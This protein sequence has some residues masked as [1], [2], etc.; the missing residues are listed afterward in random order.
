MSARPFVLVTTGR[1][2]AAPHT[3]VPGRVRPPRPEVHLAE[4]LIDAI[5]AAGG[6]PLLLP[7]TPLDVATLAGLLERVDAVVISGGAF[8]IHP[9]H[10]GQP[11]RGRVDSPDEARTGTELALIRAALDVD[12]PLLGVCGGMQ[13]MAVATG[14]SLI[15]DIAT[16]LA[17]SLPHEQPG[18]P[19][20]PSHRVDLSPGRL[21]ELFGASVEVNSTHHQAVAHPGAF[22]VTGRAPDGVVEAI[23][24]PGHRFAVG[25]QWH[26]ELLGQGALFAGLVGR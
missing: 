7:P 19:A 4:P 25:V 13:A 17:E 22:T 18:D 15:Q 12:L 9:R 16:E 26:P 23:E 24:L 1:R 20:R 11:A 6:Q 3:P 8:D 14:G 21:R 5:C 2:A 10:Y